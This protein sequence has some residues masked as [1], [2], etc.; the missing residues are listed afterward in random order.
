MTTVKTELNL[1]REA[2]LTE[3]AQFILDDI[4]SLHISDGSIKTDFRVSVGYPPRSTSRSKVVAVC[5]KSDASADKLS[6]IFVTPAISD[7]MTILANLSHELV[8]YSDDCQS[9]HKNH[10]ARVARAIGLEGKLTATVA[11]AGLQI[12]L[13]KIIDLLGEIPHAAIDI[14]KAKAKQTTRLLKVACP[15]DSCG[16]NY[17][18]SH[19][20]IVKITDLLCPACAIHDMETDV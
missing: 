15:D 2:W 7:S 13:R 11:G 10:F 4:I 20:Q 18:A 16:F 17:R 9:G 19:M 6:E 12:K 14:G 8:H 1:D 3:A 5:I